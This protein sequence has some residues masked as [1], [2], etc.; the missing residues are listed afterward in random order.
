MDRIK[1]FLNFLWTKAPRENWHTLRRKLKRSPVEDPISAAFR[2]KHPVW[3]RFYLHFH[4]NDLLL[5]QT[6]N[7]AFDFKEQSVLEIGAGPL[8][9]Y[10]P[11]A[12]L[13]GV[14]RYAVVEPGYI[15]LRR[16]EYFIH[17]YLGNMH[18]LFFHLGIY[19]GD[20]KTFA[21][22]L[23]AVELYTAPIQNIHL[24]GQFD[25]ILS[26]AVFEHV[27]D[28]RV[29]VEQ[30][31]AVTT[32]GGIH[33]HYVDF[34]NHRRYPNDQL[35]GK[36]TVSRER[37]PLTIAN[38]GDLNL[39]TPAEMTGIF[40]Q[41]FS[42]VKFVPLNHADQIL[43]T[44]GGEWRDYAIEDLKIINGAIIAQANLIQSTTVD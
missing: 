22:K 17:N 42:T 40:R 31:A 11:L 13:N 2:G 14:N 43:D 15:D 41:S 20:L 36:Y 34:S 19:P 5:K 1:H 35:A 3:E 27:E 23:Q 25:L 32:P 4:R 33:I 18:A 39:I 8:L 38:G 16:D 26:N 24:N 7:T 12:I 10:A 37:N 29:T 30:L 6:L 9:G 44:P 21:E 28:V